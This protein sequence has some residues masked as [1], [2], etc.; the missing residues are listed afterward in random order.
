MKKCVH[1]CYE[2]C[3]C[4]YSLTPGTL[5]CGHQRSAKSLETSPDAKLTK[6]KALK[7]KSRNLDTFRETTKA[8]NVVAIKHIN[9]KQI[10]LLLILA[11]T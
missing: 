7:E 1:N 3:C 2:H 9:R 4:T 5:F 10:I 8:Y 6:S 11:V